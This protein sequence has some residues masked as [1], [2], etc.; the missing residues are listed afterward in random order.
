MNDTKNILIVGV[1][2]QG[3]IL[4]SNIISLAALKAGLD[5]KKSEI[6]GMS[7]RGGS[8]FSHV[9]YGT[10]VHSPVIP[11]GK[12]DII[13]SLEEMEVLRWTDFLHKETE[14][15]WL[16]HRILPAEVKEYPE[17]IDNEL[18]ANFNRIHQI[19]PEE[20]IEQ[21]GNKKYLNVFILGE[22]SKFTEFPEDIWKA[23]IEEL[24]PEGTM[25][26]NWKAFNLGRNSSI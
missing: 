9:R 22:L 11:E 15:I 12:A 20:I 13:V 14:V 3:T 6:H 4:A 23:A 16:K 24:V 19:N 2:G 26:D 21:L 5:I 10:T 18:K 25:D 17:G 7:Q 8:V 1:G